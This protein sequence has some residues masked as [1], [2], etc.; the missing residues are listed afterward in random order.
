MGRCKN[1]RAL[2]PGKHR[3]LFRLNVEMVRNSEGCKK[4]PTESSM[5]SELLLGKSTGLQSFFE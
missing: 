1:N 2:T 3:I 4:F 5:K